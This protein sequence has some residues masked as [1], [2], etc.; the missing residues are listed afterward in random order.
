MTGTGTP[1]NQRIAERIA[2]LHGWV[3]VFNRVA[4]ECVRLAKVPFRDG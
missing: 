2:N 1:I 3:D 4:M